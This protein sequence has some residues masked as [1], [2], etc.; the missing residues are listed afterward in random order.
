MVLRMCGVDFEVFLIRN[1][2]MKLLLI[3]TGG[4]VYEQMKRL[5]FEY[6]VEVST[7]KNFNCYDAGR[8]LVALDVEIMTERN[9]VFRVRTGLSF[10]RN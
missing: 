6:G 8:L 2:V 5:F 9:F 7:F 1:G 10:L 4:L 3:C